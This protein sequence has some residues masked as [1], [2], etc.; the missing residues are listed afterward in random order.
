M[1]RIDA[2]AGAVLLLCQ[3]CVLLRLLFFPAFLLC[4]NGPPAMGAEWVVFSLTAALG[5]TNGYFTG[6]ETMAGLQIVH[7]MSYRHHQIG[8]GLQMRNY[9]SQPSAS[10]F[11]APSMT[12]CLPGLQLVSR[13]DVPNKNVL[14]PV[15]L[16]SERL[17]LFLSQR[18]D[19]AGP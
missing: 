9:F 6:Y 5:A 7:E 8:G 11:V 12:L 17:V 15:H 4:L 2:D 3:A 1:P 16:T 18:S 19:D 10:P 14:Y 13:D